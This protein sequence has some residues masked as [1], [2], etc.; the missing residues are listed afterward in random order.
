M[1][2]HTFTVLLIRFIITVRFTIAAFLSFDA[3]SSITLELEGGADRAVFFITAVIAFRIAV[4]APRHGD[5]VD[6]SCRA[7]KLLCGARWGV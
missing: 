3:V 6:F 2:T 5:A 4:T 7:G 1:C